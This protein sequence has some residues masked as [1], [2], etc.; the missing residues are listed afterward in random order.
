VDAEALIAELEPITRHQAYLWA[1]RQG[2]VDLADDFAQ[3]ARIALWRAAPDAP[4]D[5]MHRVR[6]CTVVIKRGIFDEMRRMRRAN[7]IQHV[8][9]DEVNE[10]SQPSHAEGA[11][12]V[13][14][15]LAAAH[16]LTP[17][18]KMALTLMLQGVADKDIAATL[19]VAQARV[20]QHRMAIREW[21][22]RYV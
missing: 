17:A 19:G 12:K 11:L 14:Q 1:Q 4:A 8:E 3:C 6:W 21:L 9:I 7:R 15:A 13:Q 20:S 16:R 10:P 5:D 2:R 18:R 22:A